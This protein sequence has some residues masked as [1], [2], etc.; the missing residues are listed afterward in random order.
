MSPSERRQN[1]SRGTPDLAQRHLDKWI[2]QNWAPYRHPDISDRVKVA[3]G[4]GAGGLYIGV[5]WLPGHINGVSLGCA[6]SLALADLLW[7]AVQS[8]EESEAG[9]EVPK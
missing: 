4:G 1:L 9:S 2:A 8:I 3:I 6:E 7:A 5:T